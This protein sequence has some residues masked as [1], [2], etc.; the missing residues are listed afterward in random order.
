MLSAS[1]ESLTSFSQKSWIAFSLARSI[2]QEINLMD[3]HVPIRWGF[4]GCGQATEL[5]ML[6]AFTE[7]ADAEVVAVMSRNGLRA[8][9][10]AER[11]KIAHW[12]ADAQNLVNDPAVDAVYIAT[13]PSTHAI[14][15]I[16]ALK[17]GKAVYV[18][19]PLATSYADCLR[20]NHIS[21]EVRRPC[22]VAYYRRYLPYFDR[23]RQLLEEGTIGKVLSAQI[24]FAVPP[25]DWTIVP[26]IYLGACNLI[27]PVGD[28][29]MIWR[30]IN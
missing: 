15:A 20:I 18:E 19:K 17:A 2:Q 28:I 26:K 11:H 10:F 27:S 9:A 1:R 16:M 21:A 12:Y 30:H 3:R 4:I 22:F 7:L 29:F 24:R 8:R 5:K 14:F 23:V 13:P 25:R 6:P